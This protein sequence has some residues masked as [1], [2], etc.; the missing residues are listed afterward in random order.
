MP[1]LTGGSKEIREAILLIVKARI[2]HPAH[3]L[4]TP[5]INKRDLAHR[6]NLAMDTVGL[7]YHPFDSFDG[8]F[9]FMSDEKAYRA[10]KE[11]PRE[12][13][14][15]DRPPSS[16]N[17]DRRKNA[18]KDWFRDALF[19]LAEIF[20]E[21]APPKGFEE[22]GIAALPYGSRSYFPLFVSAILPAF[23]HERTISPKRVAKRWERMAKIMRT[24]FQDAL[25]AEQ[26]K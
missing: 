26:E 7:L 9:D 5:P 19:R 23:T 2:S 14:T 1:K 11:M 25:A 22:H 15:T 16:N 6:I 12:T 18:T 21:Y 17:I 20:S 10:R 24:S 3:P 4:V 8:Q 13:K